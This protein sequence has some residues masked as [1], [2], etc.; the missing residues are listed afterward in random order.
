ML[1][2]YNDYISLAVLVLITLSTIRMGIGLMFNSGHQSNFRRRLQV[3]INYS[4]NEDE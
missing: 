1:E 2:H 3:L 4:D